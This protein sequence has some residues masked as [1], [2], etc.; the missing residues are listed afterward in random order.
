MRSAI[1][2]ALSAAALIALALAQAPG[3][4]AQMPDAR[5]MSG[6]PRPDPQL[7]TG[8]VTVRVARGSFANPVTSQTVELTVAGVAR[9]AATDA[10]GRAEFTGLASGARVKATAVIAGERLES[11]EFAVPASGGVRL[12]LIGADP[13]ADPA[14]AA[15]T[16]GAPAAQPGTVVFG[17]E[18]RFVFELGDDG[19]SVFYVLQVKNAASSPVQPEQ[20]VVF[21]L[22]VDARNAAVLEGSSPQGRVSGRR[23]EIAGPFQPGNTVVQVAYTL[24]YGRASLEV[25]QPLPLRL[26][27]VAVVAQKVGDMQ[28]NSPQMPEQRTMPANGN[29]YIA[30]R[31]GE[32]P[33]GQPLRFAFSGLPHHAT[34]PR[35]LA[36]ALAFLILVGGAWSTW[37]SGALTGTARTSHRRRELESRRDTLFDQLTALESRHR[38]GAVPPDEYGRQRRDLVTELEQVY[39]ALDEAAVPRAS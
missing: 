26:M 1:R 18:S 39:A 20:P 8:T 19:L 13:G 24:P 17:E 33:A 6:I 31:G 14:S 37:R 4:A 15:A 5:Q 22:P 10:Q 25:E 21:D 3:V 29:L 12:A 2:R 35:D 11:Q 28:L 23:V 34:W 9:Q 30:G 27:H 16:P 36:L 38:E 32:V 7:P